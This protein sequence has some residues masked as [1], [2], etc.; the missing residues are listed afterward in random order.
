M[1]TRV[2]RP[3]NGNTCLPGLLPTLRF[4]T[5]F[6]TESGAHRDF[7]A[8]ELQRSTC[9]ASQC[10]IQ[11]CAAV[12]SFSV[13]AGDPNSGSQSCMATILLT[14]ASPSPAICIPLCQVFST[15]DYLCDSSMSVNSLVCSFSLDIASMTVSPFTYSNLV[16]FPVRG[17]SEG[18]RPKYSPKNIECT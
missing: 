10:W 11:M 1:C 17:Y 6:L 12:P 2:L 4:R 3:E 5:R 18:H 7:P 13:D 16:M 15:W 8:N 9:P 14:E